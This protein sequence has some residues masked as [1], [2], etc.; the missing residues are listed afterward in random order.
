[1]VIEA[2]IYYLVFIDSVIANLGSWFFPKWYKENFKS[3]SKFLPMTRGWT[4]VYLILVLWLGFAL[5][6]LGVL[7]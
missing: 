4:A 2:I 1:M 6:R 3:F 5:W 7:F